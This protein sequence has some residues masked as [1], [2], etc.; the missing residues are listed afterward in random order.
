MDCT[1][2]CSSYSLLPCS[3]Y[4]KLVLGNG[5]RD[6]GKIPLPIEQNLEKCEVLLVCA[7]HL[8]CAVFEKILDRFPWC[9][10]NFFISRFMLKY[11]TRTDILTNILP[12]TDLCQ[13]EI[14]PYEG[15]R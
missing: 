11:S 1:A 6:E 15:N 4:F 14:N 8:V 13:S 7:E 10:F 5:P 2:F 3:G 9:I 12:D